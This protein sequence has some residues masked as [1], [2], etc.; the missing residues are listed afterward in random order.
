VLRIIV[1]KAEHAVSDVVYSVSWFAKMRT[2]GSGGCR[3]GL[4]GGLGGCPSGVA[5]RV[6]PM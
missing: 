1:G 3:T 2:T 4:G 6:V 5:L